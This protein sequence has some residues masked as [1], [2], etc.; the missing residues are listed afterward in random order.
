MKIHT[1][2][3]IIFSLAILSIIIAIIF[4]FKMPSV[5]VTHWG[6]DNQPNGSMSSFWGSFLMPIVMVFLALLLVFIPRADPMKKNIEKFNK[7]YFNFC[8]LILS[9]FVVIQGFVIAWNLGYKIN[10]NRIIVPAFS[11]IFFYMGVLLMNAKQNM[12]IGIRTPW[13]LKSE[14][15]WNETHRRTSVLMKIVALIMLGGL[16]FEKLA[17]VLLIAPLIIVVIYSFVYSY[18]LYEKENKSVK[19]SKKR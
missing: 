2:E 17:F 8:I 16:F 12:S 10:I 9:F 18:V 5:V 7:Y 15:V 4:Y 6:I 11:I 1:K 14:K 19:N 13:T 3:W